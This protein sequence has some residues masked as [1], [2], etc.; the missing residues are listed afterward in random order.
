MLETP[1]LLADIGATNARLA[2]TL[3]GVNLLHSKV[4]KTTDFNSLETLL[5][6]YLD[7]VNN[8]PLITKAVIGVAAPIF[9]DQVQFVNNNFIFSKDELKNNLFPEGLC[10]VNDLALQA[11]VIN[12]L[13]SDEITTIGGS[14]DNNLGSKILINPGTGLGVAGIIG[15]HIIPTEAGHLNIPAKIKKEGLDDMIDAFKEKELRTPTFEDFLSGKGIKFFY[16]F[17]SNKPDCSLASED[18]FKNNSNDIYASKTKA[19]FIYLFAAY[20]RYVSL[21]WGALGGVYVAG[22]IVDSLMH[23]LDMKQF[24]SIFEDSETMK[25]LLVLTPIYHLKT[26]DLGLK[27]ALLVSQRI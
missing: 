5:K 25:S 9:S 26:K 19:L 17:L 21:V 24:R 12:Y 22:S 6:E 11:E 27:G 13:S 18:I 7:K 10:L 3:D 15:K 20:L 4:L 14:K 16:S 2:Y 8:D 1:T 23:D